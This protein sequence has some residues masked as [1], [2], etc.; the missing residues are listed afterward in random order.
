MQPITNS[1]KNNRVYKGLHNWF[2]LVIGKHHPDMYS[3]LT[4]FQKEHADTESS[5]AENSV[6]RKSKNITQKKR[7]EVENTPHSGRSLI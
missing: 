3:T 4:K 5:L 1:H 6:K 2:W 7:L